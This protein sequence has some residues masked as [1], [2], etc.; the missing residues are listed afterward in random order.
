M[1][2]QETYTIPENNP[3][4]TIN[5]DLLPET[6]AWGLRNPW[7]FSFDRA[8]GDLYIADVGQSRWEEI[9][10]EPAGSEGGFNYGWRPYE[11]SHPY[12]GEPAPDPMVLPVAEYDHSLG[13]SVTGGYVYRGEAL[14]A[15]DGVYFYGDWCSGRIWAAFRDAAG[16]WQSLPFLQSG[17]SISS[18]GQDAAGEI[19]VVDYNR[20][21]ILLLTAR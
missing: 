21:E 11:G 4:F 15:L 10:F 7:R 6:W 17:R 20:G 16:E 3:A 18:F 13:C 2:D 9:N 5:P 14:P 12:S 1:R 19:Y 8:T